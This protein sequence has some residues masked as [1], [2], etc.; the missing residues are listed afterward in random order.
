MISEMRMQG[1]VLKQSAAYCIHYNLNVQLSIL[2][3]LHCLLPKLYSLRQG[4]ELRAFQ[5]QIAAWLT[6]K[7]LRAELTGSDS[8]ANMLCT[9]MDGV[10]SSELHTTTNCSFSLFRD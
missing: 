5:Q 2:A 7:S 10:S 1:P 6:I 4:C 9:G 8:E 3:N